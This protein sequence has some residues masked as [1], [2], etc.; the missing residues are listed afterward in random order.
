MQPIIKT[1]VD[2][3]F[4]TVK[5]VEHKKIAIVEF[6]PMKEGWHY[7]QGTPGLP[8]TMRH[9]EGPDPHT[10]KYHLS[11]HRREA[12]LLLWNEG[13]PKD[14]PSDVDIPG[15]E[16]ATAWENLSAAKAAR[17]PDLLPGLLLCMRS[18]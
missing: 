1:Q 12:C 9:V 3:G 7:S 17:D 2:V 18:G 16:G 4:E 5:V 8:D 15:E 14:G 13:T 6:T 11:G 10:G